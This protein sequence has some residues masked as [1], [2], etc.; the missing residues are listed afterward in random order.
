MNNRWSRPPFLL[1]YE[2]SLNVEE[3][4]EAPKVRH[5]VDLYS[6]SLQYFVDLRGRLDNVEDNVSRSLKLE[7]QS[8]VHNNSILAPN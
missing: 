6:I 8:L 1:L 5:A 4:A 7:I 3:Q 2:F